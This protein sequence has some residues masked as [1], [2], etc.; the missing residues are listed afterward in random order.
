VEAKL[1]S[2]KTKLIVEEHVDMLVSA[3]K[4]TAPTGAK[5]TKKFLDQLATDL[6]SIVRES[7]AIKHLATFTW[8]SYREASLSWV[9]KQFRV[10]EKKTIPHIPSSLVAVKPAIKKANRARK[11]MPAQNLFLLYIFSSNYELNE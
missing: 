7:H 8:P 9:R 5:P 10:I 11:S 2:P 4:I 3:G 1:K 6:L